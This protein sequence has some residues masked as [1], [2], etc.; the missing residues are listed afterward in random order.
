[1]LF[2]KH[3]MA[4]QEPIS[5]HSSLL[6]TSLTL[7]VATVLKDSIG[8]AAELFAVDI[9]QPGQLSSFPPIRSLLMRRRRIRKDILQHIA[10]FGPLFCRLAFLSCFMNHHLNQSRP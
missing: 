1:M 9:N 8:V 2:C 5:L 10:L 7:F 4:A 3:V 6:E